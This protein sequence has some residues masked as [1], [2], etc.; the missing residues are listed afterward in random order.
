MTRRTKHAATVAAVYM[1]TAR[2]PTS[3]VLTGSGGTDC[4]FARSIGRSRVSRA[5]RHPAIPAANPTSPA[6]A[7]A[8]VT[9]SVCNVEITRSAAVPKTEVAIANAEIRIQWPAGL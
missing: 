4:P 1:S 6:P 5:T 2:P 7:I 3:A 8:I 9:T